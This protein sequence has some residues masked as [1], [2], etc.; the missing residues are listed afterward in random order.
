MAYRADKRKAKV[1]V[2]VELK[3]YY[4]TYLNLA[5]S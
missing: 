2:T 5:F 4:P 1:I 3:P